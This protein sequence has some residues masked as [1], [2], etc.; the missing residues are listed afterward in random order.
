MTH[1]KT[2]QQG[3]EIPPH[4]LRSIAM[5]ND[6]LRKQ[7]RFKDF[8][9]LQIIQLAVKITEDTLTKGESITFSSFVRAAAY[10]AAQQI[11]KNNPDHMKPYK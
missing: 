6:K 11:I 9:Q 10:S 7:I 4:F 8:E 5:R 1:Q 2:N 3:G